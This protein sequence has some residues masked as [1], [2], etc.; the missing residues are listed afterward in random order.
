MDPYWF[1]PNDWA[2]RWFWLF[3]VPLA[4][5]FFVSWGAVASSTGEPKY[6]VKASRPKHE[7]TNAAMAGKLTF[8]GAAVVAA[9]QLDIFQTTPANK[10]DLGVVLVVNVVF[11]ALAASQNLLVDLPD[12]LLNIK[13]P[14]PFKERLT[15]GVVLCS[16]VGSLASVFVIVWRASTDFIPGWVRVAFS[17]LLASAAVLVC[18]YV[19]ARLPKKPNRHWLKPSQAAGSAGKPREKYLGAGPRQRRQPRNQRAK[20]P[21]SRKPV[22]PRHNARQMTPQRRRR[23]NRR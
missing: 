21:A 14:R 20:G 17:L 3:L 9:A 19:R 8:L 18:A 2:D 6:A 4:V 5:G 7:D 10:E 23:L 11:A 22:Q 16:A 15:R 1:P 13:L 12:R